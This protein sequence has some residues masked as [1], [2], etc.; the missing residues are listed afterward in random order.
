MDGRRGAGSEAGLGRLSRRI[1]QWRAAGR[2]GKRMPEALW[3]D[4]VGVAR[5]Q[6]CYR[7][8]RA[9]G[10]NDASLRA[11]VEGAGARTRGATAA[12][13]QRQQDEQS[14][15]TTTAFAEVDLGAVLGGALAGATVEVA[16]RDG[17]RMQIR[18]AG[19]GA[20]QAAVLLAAFLG[21]AGA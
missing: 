15:S 3:D 21:E 11:R 10:L 2:P 12:A 19:A 16:R 8:A 18:L 13:G 6:G 1:E 5:A 9:L 14:A 7:V 20:A 17:A 4:A